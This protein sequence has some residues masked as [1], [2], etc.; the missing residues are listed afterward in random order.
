M[1]KRVNS[2]GK[3]VMKNLISRT[4]SLAGRSTTLAVFAAALVVAVAA[5]AGL[6]TQ[7]NAAPA[8]KANL[9]DGGLTIKGTNAADA[10]ALRLS[11]VQRG[12]LQV[13]VGDDG[14]ADFEFDTADLAA[15]IVKAGNGDD[16]VRI[17]EGNGV[18][19]DTIPTTLSGGNGNDSLTGGSGGG[20]LDGGNG[21]D[22]LAGGNGDETLFGDNG[23]DSIDGNKGAD[24]GVLG[25]GDDTFIWDPGDGSDVVEGQKGHDT[26]VFNG[27][28]A[29][30]H[31]TLR[32]IGHRLEF[33]RDVGNITM[34]TDGVERVDANTLG[35]ADVVTLGDLSGTDVREVNVDL[36]AALGGTAGD[37]LADRVVVGGTKGHDTIDVSG[38][39]AGVNVTGL[40]AKVSVSHAEPANDSLDIE[41]NGGADSITSAGLAAGV[42]QLLVDGVL[43]P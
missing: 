15:I 9:K 28:G 27:A 33:F 2:L 22:K 38:N 29:A 14:T 10:I 35:G 1:T 5:A 17:D 19:S 24:T 20:T 31:F 43:V 12:V 39:A 21:N 41:T 37:G 8:V 7:A 16:T 3:E 4:G 25:K 11:A 36:A 32:A 23:N 18:F 6:A 42:I 26:M 40:A 13:D 34:D 30:E